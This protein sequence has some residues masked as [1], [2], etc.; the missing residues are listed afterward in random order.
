M[1]HPLKDAKVMNENCK[2]LWSA[3]WLCS[4]VDS[5]FLLRKFWEKTIKLN[6]CRPMFLSPLYYLLSCRRLQKQWLDKMVGQSEFLTYLLEREPLQI[7]TTFGNYFLA[8]SLNNNSAITDFFFILTITKG[9][10]AR[11]LVQGYGPGEFKPWKWR[12]NSAIFFSVF[13]T[14]FSKKVHR[15]RIVKNCQSYWKINK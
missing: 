10:L 9:F 2:I 12:H 7:S 1:G 14:Q 3:R 8:R 6:E 15:T 13:Q 4:Y 11:W 5:A